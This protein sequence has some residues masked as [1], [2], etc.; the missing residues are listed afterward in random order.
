MQTGNG[1]LRTTSFSLPTEV[2][3]AHLPHL[4]ACARMR[5]IACASL[6]VVRRSMPHGATDPPA[7]CVCSRAYMQIPCQVSDNTMV[8]SRSICRRFGCRGT[9]YYA[10]LR[11]VC[12]GAYTP[13][14]ADFG[15][16]R[17]V[18]TSSGAGY[19]AKRRGGGACR[20]SADSRRQ[21]YTT[22]SGVVG[23][24]YARP[25]GHLHRPDPAYLLVRC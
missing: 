16:S 24:G 19:A 22:G 4:G 20:S 25:G 12:S 10:V 17:I 6:H 9:P 23:P 14:A 2:V 15:F 5:A 3:S 11:D 13:G 18:G 21:A 1:M 7:K 8:Y